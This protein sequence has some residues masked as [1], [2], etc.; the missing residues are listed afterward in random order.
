MKVSTKGQYALEIIVDL[1]LHSEKNQTESLKNIAARRNLSVKYLERE[2]S[3]IE[4]P[5]QE[6]LDSVQ[7]AIH[8][9]IWD[10]IDQRVN[11]FLHESKLSQLV[12]EYKKNL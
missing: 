12:E 7:Q 2:F 3:I 8:K 1:A 10:R 6:T 5:P 11:D 9:L 4:R